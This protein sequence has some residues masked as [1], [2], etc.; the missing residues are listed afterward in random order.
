MYF[1]KP[2]IAVFEETD[3]PAAGDPPADKP[4]TFT[5][6]EMNTVLAA[7]RRKTTK[8]NTQLAE[9]LNALKAKANLTKDERDD[10]ETRLDALQREHMTKEE[11]AAQ[12]TKKAEV[13]RKKQIEDL[14]SESS[15]WKTKYVDQTVRREIT[16]AAVATDAYLPAQIVSIL[17]HTADL[18]P[19][20]GADGKAT[21]KFV[22][23]VKLNS[24]SE[25]GDPIVLELTATEA[26][27]HMSEQPEYAN[28]F[29]AKG[30]GGFGGTNV[31]NSTPSDIKKLAQDTKAYRAAKKDGKVNFE[32]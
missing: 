28:L 14:Q 15:L 29:K 10:L 5:Q 9:E 11:L 21:D 18:V 20:I 1:S 27:K 24:V 32:Q 23:K 7:E 4:K 6:E 17:R 16:D 30:S 26:L 22:T 12:N 2:W 25:D 13:E 31:G 8:T 19:V 3:P